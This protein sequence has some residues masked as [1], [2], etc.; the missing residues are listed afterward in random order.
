MLNFTTRRTFL[1]PSFDLDAKEREKLDRFLRVLER[2]KIEELFPV[3]KG[4][5]EKEEICQRE[6]KRLQIQRAKEVKEKGA[7]TP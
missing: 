1:V 2:S 5:K 3:K 6:G 4:F 7:V